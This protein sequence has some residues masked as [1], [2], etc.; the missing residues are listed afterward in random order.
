MIAA[1]GCV[2][3][4]VMPVADPGIEALYAAWR[5]AFGRGDVKGVLA[6]LTPDYTLWLAGMRPIT[7][8]GLRPQLE[9]AFATH[10]IESTFDR[11]ECV[12]SG[13]LAVD[14]GW[15]V[16]VARPKSGGQTLT[17]RQRVWVILRR[18]DGGGWRFARGI[19]QPGPA[20]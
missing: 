8:D 20:A 19:A 14:C 5:E 17:R 13:S 4:C 2:V 11:I 1:A 16:Q 18:D 12:V 10:E 6:L 15:D 3:H 7:V 9:T